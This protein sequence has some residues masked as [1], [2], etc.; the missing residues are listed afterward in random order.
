MALV[1][2]QDS[3]GMREELKRSAGDLGLSGL[4]LHSNALGKMLDSKEHRD[5]F[6]LA[7]QMR[8]PVFIH[9]T[10]P[11]NVSGLTEYRL[12]STFGLQLD[13]SLSLL[14]MIFSGIFERSK[15]LKVVVSHLGSTLPY[16]SH[17]LDD[18]FDAARPNDAKISNR[19]SEYIRKLYVDTVTKQVAPLE[20]AV[21]YFGSD[22]VLFGSDYPFWNT[23]EHMQAV[24]E[25]S[26]SA[27]DK[28]KIF[29]TNA[30]GLLRN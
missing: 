16:I 17:R 26:I 9:P 2:V 28:E 15:G 12:A 1:P 5:F 29:G 13:L 19:P 6:E 25:S 21:R 27:E 30:L 10:I 20:F 22:H 24:A 18:E 8:M 23:R 7:S 4:H 3:G 11:Y 14:R